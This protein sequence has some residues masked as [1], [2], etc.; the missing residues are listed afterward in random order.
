[1]TE[2]TPAIEAWKGEIGIHLPHLSV[3][4]RTVLALWC[5]GLVLARSCA[6]SAVAG[7]LATW[8]G[9]K[10]NTVR[11]QLREFCSEAQAKAG[12]RRQAVAV[13]QCFGPLLAWVLDH[14]VGDQL[15]LALDAT[16]LG[17][18]FVVLAVSVV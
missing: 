15:A 3:P 10:E 8:E 7:F 2:H 11:Q 1:M 17:E 5:V 9:R 12:R 16:T 18:R 6:R 4:Q 13:E 14:Y